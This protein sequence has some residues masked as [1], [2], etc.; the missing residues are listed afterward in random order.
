MLSEQAATLDENI[1]G[2][3]YLVKAKLQDAAAERIAISHLANTNLETL[4]GSQLVVL[5]D[6][7]SDLNQKELLGEISA[8]ILARLQKGEELTFGNYCDLVLISSTQQTSELDD[9]MYLA[10]GRISLDASASNSQ[11]PLPLE[12][13]MQASLH[14]FDKKTRLPVEFASRVLADLEA[15][16]NTASRFADALDFAKLARDRE[17]NEVVLRVAADKKAQRLNYE[18]RYTRIVISAATVGIIFLGGT[19]IEVANL[20]GSTNPPTN[21]QLL[22]K[23]FGSF[24]TNPLF[25]IGNLGLLLGLV[26]WSYSAWKRDTEENSS[27]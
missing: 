21:T 27:K 17:L 7:V 13:R 20:L 12:V 8:E 18:R 16:A 2:I 24:L 4:N 22:Q 9:L 1:R 11:L 6:L 10:H 25:Q 5:L 26:R 14:A 19:L 15:S 23:A 3:R